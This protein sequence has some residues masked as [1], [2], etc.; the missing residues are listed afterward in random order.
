MIMEYSYCHYRV[1]LA[2]LS[3]IP[4]TLLSMLIVIIEYS[5]II[6]GSLFGY[7]YRLTF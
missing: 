4:T 1:F 6:T 2:L 3:S 5:Y 7:Y